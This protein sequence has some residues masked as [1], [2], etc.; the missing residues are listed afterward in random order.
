MIFDTEEVSSWQ[1]IYFHNEARGH[2]IS[3]R[4]HR[5]LCIRNEIHPKQTQWNRDNINIVTIIKL[6]VKFQIKIKIE[7]N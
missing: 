5:I 3:P 2:A 4:P 1:H 7:S 6:F